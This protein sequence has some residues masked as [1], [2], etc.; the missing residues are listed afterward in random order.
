M[1]NCCTECFSDDYLKQII[2]EK[3]VIEKKCIFCHSKNVYVI[4]PKDLRNYFDP[5]INFYMT[6]LGSGASGHVKKGSGRYIWE[7]L[8]YDWGIFKN[9]KIGFQIIDEI[10][11][12]DPKEKPSFLEHPVD[13]G[14]PILFGYKG[15]LSDKLIDNWTK[16][17]EELIHKNRFFPQKKLD[18]DLLSE[19]LKFS[20][21]TIN[22]GELLYRA[23]SSTNGKK[24]SAEEMGSPPKNMAIE[25]RAN[26]Q[27]IPYLYLTSSY[28][29]A[30]SE[31]RPH[32]GNLITVGE[33]RVNNNIRVIDL[34]DPDIGSPF[35]W[36]DKL[37][38]VIDIQGFLMMLGY[39]LSKPVD[40]N[41]T[42]LEY[43]PTQYLCEFIKNQGFEGV[44]Y[45]SFSGEDGHNI[46]LFGTDKVECVSTKLYEVTSVE[47]ESE[48]V[49]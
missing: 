34:R 37:K 24:F 7:A 1:P 33:F 31:I 5:L 41:K 29:T 46:V 13:I 32:V 10:Y 23:R 40:R 25:G 22:T 4:N 35:K 9:W 12:G 45:G 48:Q 44:R 19:I 38:F 28:K 21:S 16:F 36:G 17:C 14:L 39:I 11:G 42:V 3:G 27:G 20:E 6:Q 43:L 30:L 15:E 18:I 2:K 49:G 8:T 26:P 47:V